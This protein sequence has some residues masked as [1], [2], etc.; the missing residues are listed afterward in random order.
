M[1]RK[2]DWNVFKNRKIGE[3]NYKYIKILFSF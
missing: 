3:N 2:D 1:L